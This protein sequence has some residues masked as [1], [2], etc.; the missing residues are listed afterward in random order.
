MPRQSR[1][2]PDGYVYHALN[3]SVGRASLF[4]KEGDY[5]AF[6]RVLREARE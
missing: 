2:A 1:S 3:R 6:V 5:A 4:H